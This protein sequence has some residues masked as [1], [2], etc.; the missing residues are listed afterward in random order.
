MPESE[1][2]EESKFITVGGKHIEIKPGEDI[3]DKTR[4]ALPSARGEKGT[5]RLRHCVLWC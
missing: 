5:A 1:N 3:E 2:P 4:E